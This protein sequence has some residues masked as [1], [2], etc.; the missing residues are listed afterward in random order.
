MAAYPEYRYVDCWARVS[1]RQTQ[2]TRWSLDS[3][4]ITDWARSFSKAELFKTQQ[5]FDKTSVDPEASC[6]M[7]LVFD[8][9]GQSGEDEERIE[10]ALVD[11]RK[12]HAWMCEALCLEEYAAVYFSGG[13]GFHVVVDPSALGIIPSSHV[14]TAVEMAV[15]HL[16]ELLDLTTVDYKVYQKRHVWR[17]PGS[18]HGSGLYMTKLDPSD[19]MLSAAEIALLAKDPSPVLLDEW[20]DCDKMTDWFDQF[21]ESA[22]SN[23]I[24]VRTQPSENIIKQNLTASM[25]E[26]MDD[27]LDEYF[28]RAVS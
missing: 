5:R 25:P 10:A 24:H 23:K 14:V 6:I 3:G 26:C 7:P 15:R 18:R 12:L 19:L 17:I 21:E 1:G 8:F 11:V 2:W 13:K 22:A 20:S 16:A 27:L 4:A 28:R 9:D